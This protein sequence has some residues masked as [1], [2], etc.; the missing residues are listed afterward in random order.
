MQP[1]EPKDK[2]NKKRK[3]AQLSYVPMREMSS[4]SPRTE[5]VGIK[6]LHRREDLEDRLSIAALVTLMVF[7]IATVV[8]VGGSSSRTSCQPVTGGN[9]GVIIPLQLNSSFYHVDVPVFQAGSVPRLHQL[10][11]MTAQI[12]Q[13][14]H[15]A[16]D[17]SFFIHK[18]RVAIASPAADP[19]A[20]PAASEIRSIA[21]GANGIQS[22]GGLSPQSLS[23][24]PFDEQHSVYVTV[25]MSHDS[26]AQE[27]IDVAMQP[28]CL[29]ESLSLPGG[30][31]RAG[32][33]GAPITRR[34]SVMKAVK[35]CDDDAAVRDPAV[36]AESTDRHNWLLSPLTAS[37]GV[38][39]AVSSTR[40]RLRVTSIADSLSLARNSFVRNTERGSTEPIVLTRQLKNTIASEMGAPR[41]DFDNSVPDKAA[42]SVGKIRDVVQLA[43]FEVNMAYQSSKPVRVSIVLQQPAADLFTAL[44]WEEPPMNATAL[45]TTSIAI[46][47]SGNTDGASPDEFTRMEKLA[48]AVSDR[49]LQ[50][51]S[52][53]GS[54]LEVEKSWSAN[55]DRRKQ[56][57]TILK[58]AAL[59]A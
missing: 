53:T 32:S 40:Y 54:T 2:K 7:V 41:T 51:L 15:Q 16:L 38:V 11:H 21:T 49:I 29:L 4:S 20:D 13:R 47:I 52:G 25:S 56:L 39:N 1:K 19:T 44:G 42:L 31:C 26:E 34:V 6:G 58:S 33:V 3:D 18:Q 17:D 10:T 48:L 30:V 37:R 43:S 45:P 50:Q 22:K 24:V 9:F 8:A 5:E 28:G 12:L 57:F 35:S 55:D 14:M 36:D 27:V 59:G 23:L 46:V